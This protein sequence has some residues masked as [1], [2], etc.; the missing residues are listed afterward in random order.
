MLLCMLALDANALRKVDPG[1]GAKLAPNEGLLVVAVDTSSRVSS[2]RISKV[3]QKLSAGMLNYLE[4]GRTLQL[5]AVPEGEYQWS[6]LTLL[7]GRMGVR[8]QLGKDPEF[9]F[10]VQPGKITYAGELV[11]RPKSLFNV[12]FHVSNR[13]LPVL[14]WLEAKHPALYREY[15]FLYTGHYPDP[16]PEFYRVQRAALPAATGDLN[17]GRAAPKPGV[18]PLPPKTLWAPSRVSSIAISPNGEMVAEAILQKENVYGLELIDLKAGTSQRLGTAVLPYDELQWKGDGKLL[19]T[20]GTGLN[21]QYLT[22]FHIGAAEK[23]KRRFESKQVAVPGRLVDLL[24]NEP[25][26]VLFQRF[27]SHDVLVV[28]RM[29]V[30]SKRSIEDFQRIQSKHRINVGVANDQ[31]WFADGK[32]ELRAAIAKRGEDTVLMHGSGTSF[33]QVLDLGDDESFEPLSLSFNGDLLYGLSDEGRS[34]RDLVEFDLAS[35][36][37]T[38]TLFSKPG[39]DVVSPVIDDQ[40]TPIGARY[41]EGGRLVTEYFDAGNKALTQL[42]Q[43]SFPNRTATVIDRNQDGR[44]LLLW[45][46]GSDQPP[47]LYHLDLD[48]KRASLLDEMMPGLSDRAFVRSSVLAVKGSD[49][50]PIEAYLTL[51]AGAG[52][53]ALVV[54]P[55]GGPVGVSDRLHFNQDVQFLAS[56]GYAVLQVNY[57]GS[58]GYGKAFREAGHRNHGR[59]IEDD[60]DAA[61]KT[62]LASYPL[63]EGRMCAVGSSYGGYSAMVSTI[64]WPTR[65]RCV[66]SMSGVSDRALFFTASDGGR[67]AKARKQM[68][69]IIGN[70]NT[71]MVEMQATSPLYHY[72]EL[73]VPTMLV[74]GRED[75]RVDFEHTRRLVRMLNLAGKPPVVMA[76]LDEG[77]GLEDIKN[78]DTAWTGIAGFLGEYLG[79][80]PAAAVVTGA[81][82]LPKQIAVDPGKAAP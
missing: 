28:H 74:H 3:G 6:E 49:G 66:V 76:F 14:D 63:D 46:D 71:D 68:E 77:H 56:L 12:G 80:A 35:K 33:S 73:Q 23:G 61:I 72:R 37:I 43:Q 51:P 17:A 22:V 67:N 26:K 62:A 75:I 60:I 42:L 70:P 30:S 27:D 34:Q 57:R 58:E 81:S 5:Y 41:Y 38:R 53:H 65:F 82:S 39:V 40:R 15:P 54:M 1:E 79:P 20:G 25:D 36:R 59:L 78:I 47:L 55:H 45:V 31:G 64:R 21:D 10:R 52:K 18:L 9:H 29:D 7:T 8:Y 13:S 2:L 19:V 4:A 50:L 16:F 48:Q 24:P 69:K 11:V 32:G 44:Q